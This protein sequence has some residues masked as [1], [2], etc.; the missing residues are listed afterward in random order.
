MN[1]DFNTQNDMFNEVDMEPLSA[2]LTHVLTPF[3]DN[4][5]SRKPQQMGIAVIAFCFIEGNDSSLADD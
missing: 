3:I 2:F 4:E 5:W 1:F